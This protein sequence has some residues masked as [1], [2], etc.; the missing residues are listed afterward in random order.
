MKKLY[1]L[2]LL[3]TLGTS[4]YYARGQVFGYP[5]ATWMFQSPEFFGMCF[6]VNEK[7][8]YTGDTS[9]LG[10]SA[11]AI[12]L[13]QKVAN[14]FPATSFTTYNY[15]KYFHVNGDTVWLFVSFDSTWQEI[16]NFSVQIGDTVQNPLGNRLNGWASSCPDSIPYNDYSEVIDTGS[17]LIAGQMLRYYTVRYATGVQWGPDSANQTFY[18]RIITQ[19]YWFPNDEYWCGAVPECI[20]P[21][22]ICYKDVGMMTDSSCSDLTWFETLSFEEDDNKKIRIY[23]NPTTDHLFIENGE[24]LHERLILLSVDGRIIET[25]QSTN[26]MN[27]SHLSPGLYFLTNESRTWCRKFVKQ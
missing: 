7:W 9:I 3:L 21:S 14:G 20:N 12:H 13:T 8:E 16:Y 2:L 25:L 23:P 1:L 10:T 15:D 11:K 27:V 24:L 5:G 4:N 6:E 18:E 26:S 17:T 19:N 22:F